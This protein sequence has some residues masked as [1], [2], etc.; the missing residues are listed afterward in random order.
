MVS[1]FECPRKASMA[2]LIRC[3]LVHTH[4][5]EALSAD[6]S[7]TADTVETSLRRTTHTDLQE[8]S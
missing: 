1:L 2:T 7:N 8:F 5:T 6:A 4:R 3:I